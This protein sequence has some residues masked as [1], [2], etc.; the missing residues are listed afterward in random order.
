V[1]LSTGGLI[2]G[3]MFLVCGADDASNL[4]A[5]KKKVISVNGKTGVTMRSL[6][7]A[8]RTG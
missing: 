6:P 5:M 1:V 7:S 8:A 4:P 3:E 2:G